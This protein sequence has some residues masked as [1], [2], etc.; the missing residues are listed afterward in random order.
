[1]LSV[2]RNWFDMTR[3]G[4]KASESRTVTIYSKAGTKAVVERRPWPRNDTL[5]V[6]ME[7]RRRQG[8]QGQPGGV[9]FLLTLFE[10]PRL[11]SLPPERQS[12]LRCGRERGV[13]VTT[14][15]ERRG[16]EEGSS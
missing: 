10:H 4:R 11:F 13:R 1:M 6:G 7:S 14:R 9:F 8:G 3:K 15:T 16:T 5:N 12:G 2:V